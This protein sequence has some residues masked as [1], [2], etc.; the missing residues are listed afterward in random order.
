MDRIAIILYILA[1]VRFR[2]HSSQFILLRFAAVNY[3]GQAFQG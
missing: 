1:M 2:V 3:G